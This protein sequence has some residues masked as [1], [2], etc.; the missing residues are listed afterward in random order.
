MKQRLESYG[1]VLANVNHGKKQLAKSADKV[2]KNSQPEEPKASHLIKRAPD[3]SVDKSAELEDSSMDE[4]L[5][6][7]R[8]LL[9]DQDD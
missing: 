8:A 9:A 7:Q 4:Q 3:V 2:T 6:H 5:R 1:N